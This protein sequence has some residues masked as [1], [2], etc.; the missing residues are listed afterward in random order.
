MNGEAALRAPFPYFGG[1]RR[2]ASL[3]WAALG[4]VDHYVEPFC[5]S[6]AVLLAR[7]HVGRCET[8]NDADGMVSNF[9]RAVRSA[10]DAVAAHCDWPVA[11]ADLHARHL[12]LMGQR[13][14]LTE[15]LIADPEWFDAKAAGWWVWGACAW[16]GDGWCDAK[17]SRKL[18]HLG[19][20][21]RGVH[22]P[23]RGAAFADEVVAH[24]TTAEWFRALSERL[25]A[26]RVASGDWRRVVASAAT[27]WPSSLPAR[28]VCGVMLDP[29]Y[30]EGRMDYAAGGMGSSVSADA[31]A[32]AI[33]H[34]N[35]PRLRIVLCGYEWEH[36]MPAGWR[37]VAWKAKGGYARAS[38]NENAARERLWLSPHCVEQPPKQ[39]SLFDI[40][41]AR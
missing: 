2:A 34:G 4:N 10:P 13:E 7:P 15:R 23:R 12:W 25:R 38:G 20:E 35:D 16:I 9:W 41:G 26:V 5:G 6:A 31:R 37:I 27:L 18:P 29:P 1:K 36:A 33:E 8:I 28:A 17:P 11:E 40:G 21:G 32:W 24:A 3:V 30:A 14:S 22:A 19:D 39:R